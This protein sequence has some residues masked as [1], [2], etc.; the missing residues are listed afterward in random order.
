MTCLQSL[1]HLEPLCGPLHSTS[2][3]WNWRHEDAD[4]FPICPAIC[5][6]GIVT[7]VIIGL[8]QAMGI[9]PLI[10]IGMVVSSFEVC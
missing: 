6:P 5:F 4:D 3:L 9:A 7:G 8:A 2:R 10:V 1:L